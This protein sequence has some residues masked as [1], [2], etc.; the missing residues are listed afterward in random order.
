MV[1]TFVETA[2]DTAIVAM[3]AKRKPDSSFPVV[4]PTIFIYTE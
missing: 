3:D 4:G 2:K 1:V